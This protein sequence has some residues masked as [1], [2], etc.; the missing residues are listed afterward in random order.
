VDLAYALDPVSPMWLRWFPGLLDISNLRTLKAKQGMIAHGMAATIARIAF[1][2]DRDGNFEIYVMNADGSEQT[3]LTD[4]DAFDG[5]PAWSPDG[6]KIAFASDR[7]RN[8]HLE[9]YVM[10]ADG[11]GQHNLTYT[12]ELWLNSEPAWSPDGSKIAYG[13][14]D[15]L[16]N[17]W[18]IYVMNAD[19]TGQT[20]L[21]DFYPSDS[22]PT[23]SPDGSKI[24]FESVKGNG[25]G[26]IY[27]IDAEPGGYL[28]EMTGLTKLSNP[29]P[30]VEWDDRDPAWS[31]DG[32]KIAFSENHGGRGIFVMNAD[33]SGQTRLSDYPSSD[34]NPAWSPGGSK[35]VFMSDRD[36]NY[37]I[38]VMNA[39]GTGQHSLT[40]DEGYN[41]DPAWS[42]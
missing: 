42:P 14:G 11:T 25:H 3:R 9:I 12:P 35:I 10:H 24:A 17:S 1:A 28:G 23:W 16:N 30:Y 20:Q 40:D 6:T 39:D 19:G 41:R 15:P 32:S 18:E 36:G 27:S 33:G 29:D 7:E 26:T 13:E 8:G 37:E 31:P 21:T 4:N 2:S 22:S 38:Y 34:R 5:Y